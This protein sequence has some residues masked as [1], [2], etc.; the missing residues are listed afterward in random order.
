[1]RVSNDTLRSA[2]LAALDDARRRVIDTQEKVS[3]GLRINSPADD[4]VAAARVAHLDASLARLD[5]YQANAIFARNQ[6][7]LEEEALTDVIGNLQRIRE[8]TLQANNGSASNGDRHIIAEEMRQHR[9]A[10]LTIANTTDVDGRHLFAGYK[11]A[12]V[13]F[14]TSASGSVVYNGDQ[15][16]RTL[17]IS[18]SRFVAINDSGAAVFQRIP[19]G[20]GTFVLGVNSAN[21]G[22]GTLGSSS[23][24]DPSAWV[25]DTYTVS[26][27]TP[28][29]Y[30]IRNSANALI[31]AGA[32]NPP[33]QSLT[34]VGVD[35]RIDGT[36]AAGD[37]FTVTPSA[38]RDVFATLDRLIASIDTPV[39]VPADRAQ[40]HSNIGQRLADLDGAM[41][42]LID[43]RGEI[44]ARVRALDQ[45]EDLNA[46]FVVHLNTTLSAVRDLDYAEALSQLSQELFGLDAAQQAFAR[47]QNLS[48]FK[49]L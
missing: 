2:F 13:P 34:F 42:H 3:T 27:L 9:D 49:Y 39:T 22:T 6:L 47:A 25:S 41:A 7:G 1:M 43:A 31:V 23:L 14:T 30:E 15:G 16:Q 46:D 18:D 48:L 33:T 17:Q 28:T 32:F 38:T 44:G 19:E 21:T 8:L 24:T 10:L 5:Q 40:L 26:F 12:A 37:T 35:M 4:P 29:S 36:P 11:E 20:N 45:Q